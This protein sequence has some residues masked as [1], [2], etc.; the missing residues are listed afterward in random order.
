MRVLH[1]VMMHE[2]YLASGIYHYHRDGQALAGLE[3]WSIHELPD[4][5]WFVRIDYDWRL[6]NGRSQLIE[7]LVDS[8]EQGGRFQRV[9]AHLFQ[10]GGVTTHETYDFHD[11][12]V[13][14]GLTD[15]EGQRMDV[16]LPM[17]SGYVVLLMKT[18]LAGIAAAHWPTEDM[19]ERMAFGGYRDVPAGPRIFG[20][21]CKTT[22]MEQILLSGKP[23]QTHKIQIR[24]EYEQTLWVDEYGIPL[25]RKIGDLTA[26]LHDYAHRAERSAE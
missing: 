10:P 19:S 14:I 22:G 8:S 17:T 4:A 25:R 23:V 16:E 3:H 2:K 15:S 9:V 6:E 26:D 20:A 1:P 11:T 18:V 24:G 12:Q 13:L 5:S 7:A 21:V